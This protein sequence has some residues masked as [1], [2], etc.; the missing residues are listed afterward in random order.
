LWG[1]T[2]A[3]AFNAGWR[4]ACEAMAA[5][6]QAKAGPE[7]ARYWAFKD[8]LVYWRW[9]GTQGEWV[10]SDGTIEP[11]DY[12]LHWFDVR[13]SPEYVP[14]TTEAEARRVA[15]FPVP[16]PATDWRAACVVARREY[17]WDAVS[18]SGQWWTDGT[19]WF[20]QY[21]DHPARGFFPWQHLA[22]AA[23]AACTT[24]PP[25]AEVKP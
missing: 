4:A 15:G 24:P 3:D 23:L 13:A 22:T 21:E 10:E 8:S 11:S 1:G 20:R 12:Q 16:Q 18:Q 25:D 5:K 19:D 7:R 17:G 2:K 14:C 9:T 6:A